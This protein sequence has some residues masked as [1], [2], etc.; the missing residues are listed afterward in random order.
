MAKSQRSEGQE[1]QDS[2]ITHGSEY[3]DGVVLAGGQQKDKEY[4]FHDF[5]LVVRHQG[6]LEIDWRRRHGIKIQYLLFN[7]TSPTLDL[8]EPN[9]IASLLR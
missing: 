5:S 8:Y 4:L 9:E 3:A 2:Q 6:A 1:R 7:T